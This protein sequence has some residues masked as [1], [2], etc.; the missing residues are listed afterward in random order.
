MVVYDL[1]STDPAGLSPDGFLSVLLAK[2]ERSFSSVHLLSGRTPTGLTP[3]TTL[4]TFTHNET[5]TSTLRASSR[6]FHPK[7]FTKSTFIRRKNQQDI[8]TVRIF[9]FNQWNALTVARL[10]Y[11]IIKEMI[12]N[13]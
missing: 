10:D 1:S 3:T 2:L 5:S 11:N 4:G 6:H 7:Q 8:G 12:I 9:I 13:R